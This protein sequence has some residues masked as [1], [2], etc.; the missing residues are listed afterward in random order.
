MV[1]WAKV[2]ELTDGFFV[3]CMWFVCGN[4]DVSPKSLETIKCSSIP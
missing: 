4:S 1:V 2:C 3:V